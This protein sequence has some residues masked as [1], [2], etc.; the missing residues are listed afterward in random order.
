[1][2]AAPFIEA[3]IGGVPEGGVSTT[4]CRRRRGWAGPEEWVTLT[5]VTSTGCESP[6]GDSREREEREK[7]VIFL[8]CWFLHVGGL[9][10]LVPTGWVWRR[11][12][13]T[14]VVRLSLA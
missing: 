8:S 9:V 7:S 10:S 4:E 13:R 6:G 5:A 2:G 1:M 11:P 12:C 3:A 14:S